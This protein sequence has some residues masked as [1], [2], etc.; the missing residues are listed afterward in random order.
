VPEES[1]ALEG[2]VGADRRAFIKRL[3]LGGV[4]AYPVV[5]SFT[6]SGIGATFGSSTRSTTVAATCNSSP[7]A[8]PS[9]YPITVACFCL[10]T[11]AAQ[12]L[13]ATDTNGVTLA[14]TLPA[15]AMHAGSNI[16]IFRGNLTALGSQ[17]PAGQV[18]VSAYAVKWNNPGGNT[19]ATSPLTLVV[20]DPAT[21]SG[22]QIFVIDSGAPV[23]A[24]GTTSA[25]S[26]T[27]SFTQ[28]PSFV[29]TQ[30]APAPPT[31]TTTTTTTPSPAAAVVTSP[32][33]T[34]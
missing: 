7:P 13:N 18:P 34:G 5:S 9:S 25:G 1:E 22:D 17:V 27:V 19:P 28:D 23:N 8:P 24:G 16:C 26:W 15:N 33:F 3:I 11:T 20:T 31:T 21:T 4:V 29:V 6:M 30:A 32:R 12:T 2:A 14:L 10:T